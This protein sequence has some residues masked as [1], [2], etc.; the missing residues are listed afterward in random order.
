MPDSTVSL[1]GRTVSVLLTASE[2]KAETGRVVLSV[3]EEQTVAATITAQDCDDCLVKLNVDSSKLELIAGSESVEPGSGSF[4]QTIEWRLRA[5]AP[6]KDGTIEITVK[7]RDI[8]TPHA[9][10]LPLRIHPSLNT[11]D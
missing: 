8:R 5:I 11:E 6:V 10:F 1:R 4:E 7:C 2:P 9:Y 3:G